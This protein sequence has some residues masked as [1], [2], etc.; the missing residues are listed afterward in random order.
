[1]SASQSKPKPKACPAVIDI[2][3]AVLSLFDWRDLLSHL[4]G[5]RI[6]MKC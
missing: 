4:I 6:L 5:L 3:L 1:M 2:A